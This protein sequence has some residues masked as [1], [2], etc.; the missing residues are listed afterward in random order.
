MVIKKVFIIMVG[1]QTAK[2]WKLKE[3]SFTCNNPQ[4]ANKVTK[5]H[6]LVCAEFYSEK[7]K[8]PD[9]LQGHVKKQ[10]KN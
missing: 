9:F 2:K 6:C 8:Q 5:I 1:M 4:D 10:V 3:F 7:P